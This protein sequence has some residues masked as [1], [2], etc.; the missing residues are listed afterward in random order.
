MKSDCSRNTS[1]SIINTDKE[2]LLETLYPE[3]LNSFIFKFLCDQIQKLFFS[4]NNEK[5]FQTH[6]E[7]C[8]ML[9]MNV[10]MSATQYMVV[11]RSLQRDGHTVV[12][13][14]RYGLLG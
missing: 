3:L 4:N 2:Y 11:K 6:P 13:T 8:A 1:N 14:N 7:L 10:A 9:M 12:Q 5:P